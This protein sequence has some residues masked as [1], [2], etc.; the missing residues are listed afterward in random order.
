MMLLAIAADWICAIAS[1]S[2]TLDA[3]LSIIYNPVLGAEAMPPARTD[4][5]R[6]EEGGALWEVFEV[7]ILEF[8]GTQ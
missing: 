1:I 6:S 4:P 8:T 2:S 5:Q 7:E 3:G